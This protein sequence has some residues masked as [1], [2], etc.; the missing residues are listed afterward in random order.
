MRFDVA[1]QLLYTNSN[2]SRAVFTLKTDY[3]G[4]FGKQKVLKHPTVSPC[5]TDYIINN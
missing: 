4:I 3:T 1:C 5:H 2:I